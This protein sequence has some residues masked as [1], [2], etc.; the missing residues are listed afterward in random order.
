MG[1]NP[2][3]CITPKHKCHENFTI[4]VLQLVVADCCLVSINVA[5]GVRLVSIRLLPF[6]TSDN[7][8]FLRYRFVSDKRF[9]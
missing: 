9:Y 4:C 3:S 6:S 7:I 1:I 5:I 8:Q 2:Y